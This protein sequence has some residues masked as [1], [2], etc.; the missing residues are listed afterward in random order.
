MNGYQ[1]TA[2]T[3]SSRPPCRLRA[4]CDKV[5]VTEEEHEVCHLL[6]QGKT[7]TEIA[8]ILGTSLQVAENRV[9]QLLGKLGVGNRAAAAMELIRQMKQSKL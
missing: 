4:I 8:D 9:Q 6:I 7:N 2:G 3:P 1:K 5:G